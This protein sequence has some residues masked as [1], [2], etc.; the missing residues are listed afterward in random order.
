MR[1]TPLVAVLV[2]LGTAGAASASGQHV[3]IAWNDFDAGTGF[4]GAIS[5]SN[6]WSVSR[7]PIS[8]G[9]DSVLHSA[10]GKLYVVSP[11]DRTVRVVDPRS[12]TVE[13]S[14]VLAP[15]DDPLDIKVVSPEL[16]YVTRGGARQLLEVDLAAGTTREGV[17]LSVLADADGVPDQGTMAVHDGRLFI[18]LRRVNF[19]DPAPFPQPFVAVVD[20]ASN[21]LVDVDP[22]RAGLQAIE[23][24]GTFPKMK[25]QVVEQ[26]GKLLV[27]ATGGFF[28]DGGIEVVDLDS[29]RSEG[30]AI[31]E[32]D[33]FTGADLGA[34]V[35][36]GP[37]DGFLVYST[38]LLLSSHLHQFSLARGVDPTEL[39]VA[40]D[41]FSPAVEFHDPTN[42]VFFPLGGS[43]ENGLLAF[44]AT[45]GARLTDQLIATSG[46]PTDLIALAAVPEPT[47]LVI[48]L[49]A[50]LAS[51]LAAYSKT[52]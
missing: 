4:L 17:D 29:L 36:V 37:E 18:Q 20:L 45:T 16:A 32:D 33:D 38:D 40:L 5:A 27:S 46:P 31:R 43:L 8:V 28:D 44:D 6:P 47:G 49:V 25:M 51:V 9:L 35:M 30:L 52:P 34:F 3:A 23:L 2:L 12:W 14:I 22:G 11:G 24:D 21:Q 50:T 48:A 1:S 39:A 13:R 41:Y 26:T 10:F 42:T 7:A 15:G 19:D